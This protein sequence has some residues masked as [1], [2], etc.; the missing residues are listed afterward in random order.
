MPR[1]STPIKPTA[2]LVIEEIDWLRYP[3]SAE[4]QRFR[5]LKRAAVV[6]F[7]MIHAEKVKHVT[8]PI[9]FWSR[10]CKNTALF[11]ASFCPPSYSQSE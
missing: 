6:M 3:S 5:H 8:S 10:H 2:P 9:I 1:L 11:L 7:L 4:Y